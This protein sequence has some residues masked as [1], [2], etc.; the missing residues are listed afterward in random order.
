MFIFM[1]EN[2]RLAY[3]MLKMHGI[4]LL[5]QRCVCLSATLLEPRIQSDHIYYFLENIFVQLCLTFSSVS[6]FQFASQSGPQGKITSGQRTRDAL[7][8]APSP[9]RLT[10]SCYFRKTLGG[11]STFETVTQKLA[12]ERQE[13]KNVKNKEKGIEEEEAAPASSSSSFLWIPGEDE[14][15]DNDIFKL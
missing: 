13:R 9:D 3:I 5:F 7:Q 12:R 15:A 10:F 8:W 6:S 1:V 14:D 2:S 4:R 11:D